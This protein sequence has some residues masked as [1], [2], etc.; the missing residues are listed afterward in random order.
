MHILLIKTYC[1]IIFI[2]I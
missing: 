2:N 1:K